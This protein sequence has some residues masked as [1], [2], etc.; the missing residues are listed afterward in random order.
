MLNANRKKQ[1]KNKTSSPQCFFTRYKH[2]CNVLPLVS[3]SAKSIKA[4]KTLAAANISFV[5]H[6]S[7]TLDKNNNMN[8]PRCSSSNAKLN[9]TT[10]LINPRTAGAMFS[11]Q[12]GL[13]S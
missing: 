4:P 5:C 10:L 2:Y 8:I 13:A 9:N 12:L 1:N 7:F 3:S 11:S 6:L